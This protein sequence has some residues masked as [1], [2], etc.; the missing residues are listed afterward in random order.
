VWSGSFKIAAFAHQ[1]S[2]KTTANPEAIAIQRG[3]RDW[4]CSI[5][6]FESLAGAIPLVQK[7]EIVENYLQLFGDNIET[8]T[9]P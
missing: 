7:S 5:Y 3:V 4:R 1:P 2:R 8:C 6:N 9:L